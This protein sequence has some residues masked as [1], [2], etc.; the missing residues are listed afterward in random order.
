MAAEDDLAPSSPPSPP[1]APRR[2]V[3]RAR[4]G[5]TATEDYARVR[6]PG[7]PDLRGYLAAERAWYDAHAARWSGLAMDLEREAAA[8]TPAA[9][10]SVQWPAAGGPL[11]T[12]I[13]A[14]AENL[15]LMRVSRGQSAQVLRDAEEVAAATGFADIGDRVPS[16]DGRLLA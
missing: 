3:R 13:P 10:D 15:R 8:R 5:V 4:H 7:D 2:P 11:L 6:D 1:R 12:R 14:G 9:T 16:P